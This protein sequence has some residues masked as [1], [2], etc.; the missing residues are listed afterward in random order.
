MNLAR[1]PLL[2]L[3]MAGSA[4]LL[5]S[6]GSADETDSVR[7]APPERIRAGGVFLGEGRLYP[8]PVLY[9]VDGDKRPDILVGDLVGK[10]TV[11]HRQA[12]KTAVA[13]DVEKPLQDR[14]GKPLRFHNW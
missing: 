3:A 11:A 1:V 4:I 8:S 5:S 2:A 14:D 10:V 6:R 12:A 7:F 9:D 13:F